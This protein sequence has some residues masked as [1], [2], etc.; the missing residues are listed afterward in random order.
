MPLPEILRRRGR[1]EM[2]APVPRTNRQWV[3]DISRNE[4]WAGVLFMLESLRTQES[5]QLKER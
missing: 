2:R 4:Q 5:M 3:A 1:R